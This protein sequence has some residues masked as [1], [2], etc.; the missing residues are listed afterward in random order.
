MKPY[1]LLLF[2][3]IALAG[4][5]D[6]IDASSK[7]NEHYVWWVDAKT[8]K[9]GWIPVEG[10]GLPVQNGRFTKFFFNG[11]VFSKGRLANGQW[12]D[13]TVYYDIHGK[14]MAEEYEHNSDTIMYFLHDGPAK[15]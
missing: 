5:K 13:T 11:N 2:I 8:G 9:A 12:V 3:V 15:T 14:P 6:K 7:R 1:P 10:A 4:C